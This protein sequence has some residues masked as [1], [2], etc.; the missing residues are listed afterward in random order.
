MFYDL[1]DTVPLL[2]IAVLFLFVGS[3]LGIIA[4]LKVRRISNRL[5]Q[6]EAYLQ[7][8]QNPALWGRQPTADETTESLEQAPQPDIQKSEHVATE[9]EIAEPTPPEEEQ[10]AP[11]SLPADT[12]VATPRP[13]L[14]ERLGAKWTVWVGGLALV[15]GG[16]FLVRYSIE[17]GLL[18]PT[19]RVSAGALLAILLVGAG[20]FLRRRSIDDT[21]ANRAYIPGVLTLAGITTAFASIFAAH[22]LYELIGPSTAFILLAATALLTLAASL[23]HGPTIASYG[24]LASYV[25]P[26]L[27]S[28]DDPALWPLTL[29]GLAVSAA[30]YS[31]ARLR[32]WRW[33]AIATAVGA[34]FWGHI[35][36]FSADG[37]WDAGALI[38]YDLAIFAMAAFVFVI[39]LYPR[40][41]WYIPEKQDWLASAI[42]FL[43]VFLILYMLQESDFS[44]ASLTVLVVVA[45]SLILIAMEWPVAAAT[46]I[47]AFVLMALGLLSWDVALYP[48][49]LTLNTLEMERLSAAFANP[50]ASMF[51]K[52]GFILAAIGGGLGFW[53]AWR[54]AGRW[55]LA[56][57]SVATPLA[58]LAIAY[59][60]LA[61][62]ETSTF[63][64]ALSLILAMLFLGALVFLD[65]RLHADEPGREA[66]LAAY[67]I[68]ATGAIAGGMTI[69]LGDGWLPVSL[70]L[71]TAAIIWVHGIWRL[72]ALPWVAL[73][74]ALLTSFVIWR[75]PTIVQPVLLSTRPFFNALLYGYGVPALTFIWCAWTLSQRDHDRR[76]QQ[77]FEALAVFASLVTFAVLIHHAFN[78]GV[79]SAEPD[80]LA[81]WSLHTLVF[82]AGSLAVRRI[83]LRATSPVLSLAVA[84]LGVMGFLSTALLHLLWLNPLF[85]GEPIGTNVVFNLLAPAYLLPAILMGLI[86]QQ[87]K[88]ATLPLYQRVASILTVALTFA[89]LSLQVRAVFHR[90]FLDSGTTTDAEFYTYSALWLVFGIALLIIG[91]FLNSR[92][93]RLASSVFVL[94][95]VAKVFLLDMAGLDGVWRALSFIGLGIALIGV[96]MLYQKLLRSNPPTT[97]VPN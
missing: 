88:N 30:A 21:S 6:L 29:Y 75:N 35:L 22:A 94:A 14:E 32:L 70:G 77:A 37:T 91:F 46:A 18:T 67:A 38:A 86:V 43:H 24:L 4:A 41:R 87:S 26:F 81:E 61:P 76:V 62:F 42:L 96:G 12:V 55:A 34:L 80:T 60:R 25:V 90:P 15:L 47:A 68:G 48:R 8:L 85:T 57:C 82:L 49:D 73:G 83:N 58:L 33:F 31:V 1:F 27:V 20:E 36:A 19:A 63:F 28:S 72:N 71:L 39:S 74:T 17:A 13:S 3:G 84:I 2:L 50:S 78:G 7:Q 45:A 59:F 54:S 64:G 44:G 89:W 95:A 79:L 69:L 52:T 16:I 9:E 97:T 11:A 92:S 93:L 40:N 10:A 51:P 53:G 65:K 23:L 5:E 66:T 56:T